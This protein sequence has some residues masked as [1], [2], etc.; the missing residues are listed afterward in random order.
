MGFLHYLLSVYIF[1]HTCFNSFSTNL[2]KGSKICVVKS[3]L[4]VESWG[5]DSRENVITHGPRTNTFLLS[6]E[7][8]INSPSINARIDLWLTI[9]FF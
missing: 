8:W 3:S 9:L 6:G 7:N 1:L 2:I 5:V 4:D